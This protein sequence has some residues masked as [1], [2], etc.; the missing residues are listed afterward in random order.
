METIGCCLYGR[1]EIKLFLILFMSPTFYFSSYSSVLAPFVKRASNFFRCTKFNLPFQVSLR[2][3]QQHLF[4]GSVSSMG[5]LNY[6]QI[7]GVS[8]EADDKD[9]RVAY[10]ELAKKFHPDVNGGCTESFLEIQKAYE[11]LKDPEQRRL[12][13]LECYDEDQEEIEIQYKSKHKKEHIKYKNEFRKHEKKQDK[14]Y[15][16]G[17][18]W[19]NINFFYP[20]FAKKSDFGVKYYTFKMTG[21]FGRWSSVQK[22]EKQWRKALDDLFLNKKRL[23]R[24]R[25]RKNQ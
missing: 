18:E 22:V 23:K 6:F 21:A 14:F 4:H 16:G 11:T 10:L 25:N 17:D 1:V 19:T 13:L 12:C 20:L 2:E 24:R 7:L 8:Q 5:K 15:C 3:T 9:I